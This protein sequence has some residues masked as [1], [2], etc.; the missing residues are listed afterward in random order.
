[1]NYLFYTTDQF[2]FSRIKRFISLTTLLLMGLFVG[3]CS[4]TTP[5]KEAPKKQE[6]PK[7]KDNNEVLQKEKEEILNEL[8]TSRK[9]KF[10]FSTQLSSHQEDTGSKKPKGQT[11]K[12]K[13]RNEPSSSGERETEP[14]RS[15]PSVSGETQLD[16]ES[17]Q[18]DEQDNV[19]RK[20]LTQEEISKLNNILQ[21]TGDLEYLKKTFD[22]VDSSVLLNIRTPQTGN[23]MLLAV[24]GGYAPNKVKLIRFLHSKGF[25]PN[26]MQEKPNSKEFKGFTALGT[27]CMIYSAKDSVEVVKCLLDLGA[28]PAATG[29]RDKPN[30]AIA[31]HMIPE[32]KKEILTALVDNLRAK[33]GDDLVYKVLSYVPYGGK[34][35]QQKSAADRLKERKNDIMWI[36][37]AMGF[38]LYDDPVLSKLEI[39]T[40]IR[41]YLD[42]YNDEH[43]LKGKKKQVTQ[44]LKNIESLLTKVKDLNKRDKKEGRALIHHLVLATATKKR[45]SGDKNT[46]RLVKPYVKAGTMD[47]NIKD[48]KHDTPLHISYDMVEKKQLND[49]SVS[50]Y[51]KDK[52]NAR[53]SLKISN[54]QGKYPKDLL[55][56]KRRKEIGKNYKKQGM[57]KIRSWGSKD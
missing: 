16:H 1:M 17:T 18:G 31:C 37:E 41:Y 4:R 9:D 6:D 43:T 51:L 35:L 39:K 42:A 40:P 57:R 29:G 21:T 2:S 15:E 34:R 14:Q 10:T 23:N 20:S 49:T 28:D 7:K 48:D 38:D 53:P 19:K 52:L 32:S 12:E 46:L 36:Y 26:S 54:K 30:L 13:L 33:G 56:K 25:D 3:A 45:S 22:E 47:P 44:S 8:K 27:A 11:S 55:S 24:L 5:S 50:A